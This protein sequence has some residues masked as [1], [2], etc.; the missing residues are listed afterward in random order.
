MLSI[1]FEQF[2]TQL[3]SLRTWVVWRYET[4][5]GKRTKVP[6]CSKTQHAKSNDPA[7]WTSLEQAVRLYNAGGF[8]GIGCNIVPPFVGIDLDNALDVTGTPLP[9]ALPIL[10]A[11]PGTYV[12]V[13]P[14]GGGLH[15]WTTGTLPPFA[16]HKKTG[17]GED[18]KGAVE[19]YSEGRYFC[20]TGNRFGTSTDIHPVDLDRLCRLVGWSPEP[21]PVAEVIQVPVAPLD[22]DDAELLDRAKR[23][24]NGTKFMRLW[25]G[26]KG[27]D[28]SAADLGLCCLLAFWTGKDAARIDRIFRMSGLYRPEKWDAK[29]RADG[30]TRGK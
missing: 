16:R 4:R 10:A 15:I 25:Y 12:E 20:M 17:F 8:D 22:M 21:P 29:H 18:G 13:S 6:F 3:K 23:A 7:T 9:W 24:K 28:H 11:A 1:Q 19:V 5:G 30:A 2:P 14:S 27:D 26:D